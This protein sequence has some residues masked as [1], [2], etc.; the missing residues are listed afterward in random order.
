MSRKNKKNNRNKVKTLAVPIL[1]KRLIDL[2]SKQ[3]TTRFDAKT[4]INKLKIS[5][6][7]DSVQDCLERLVANGKLEATRGGKFK[8][9]KNAKRSSKNDKNEGKIAIGRVDVTRSG[10][11][12]IICVG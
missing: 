6:S 4:I 9:N 2:F 5:N 3:I 1:E 10:A 7:K 11:A 12:F 8:W